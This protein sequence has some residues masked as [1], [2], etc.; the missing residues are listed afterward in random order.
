[1]VRSLG[2]VFCKLLIVKRIVAAPEFVSRFV[3]SLPCLLAALRHY[4]ITSAI[5]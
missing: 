1:M 5:S 2:I 4:V 3:S